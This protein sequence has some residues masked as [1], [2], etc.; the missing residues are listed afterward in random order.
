MRTPIRRIFLFLPALLIDGPSGGNADSPADE[1]PID[2]RTIPVYTEAMW[3]EDSI[4]MLDV[5][6]RGKAERS[7]E[8]A[9]G[10]P[11]EAWLAV[12]EVEFGQVVPELQKE[13][14][15]L[16]L[17]SPYRTNWGESGI[18]LLLRTSKGYLAINPD[19]KPL[20]PEV[21]AELAAAVQ[22]RLDSERTV[23]EH[24]SDHQLYRTYFDGRLEKDIWHGCNVFC[25]AVDG[26]CQCEMFHDGERVL[27]RGFDRSGRLTFVFRTIRGTDTSFILSYWYGNLR[28]F[29]WYRDGKR[30]GVSRKYSMETRELLVEESFWRNGLR[31]GP[32]RQW[33][34]DGDLMDEAD[35]EDGLIVPVIRYSGEEPGLVTVYR[36]EFGVDYDAP[37]SIMNAFK[38][39]MSTDE[40]S[41]I[42]KLDF[43]EG[44]GIRFP[45]YSIDRY[46]HIAF[47]DGKISS[48]TTGWNGVC[49]EFRPDAE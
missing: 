1:P 4:A 10:R 39:G 12:D 45:S 25:S 36:S 29:R 35:Y 13:P 16:R 44:T 48:I 7:V 20:H 43:S 2:V 28:E 15:Q 42:L 24:L 30:T 47:Q 19:K 41:G 38:V 21:W 18:W 34:A 26:E 11:L 5:V 9:R 40:V 8:M 46:L 27:R 22:S 31:N 33:D 6:V 37:A 49:P 23:E 17:A 32:S 3:L 14:G